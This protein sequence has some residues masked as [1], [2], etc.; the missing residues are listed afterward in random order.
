M[1]IN[2][3]ILVFCQFFLT[4]DKIDIKEGEAI[5]PPRE[6][7]GRV[8][9]VKKEKVIRTE[10]RNN[11][12][13]AIEDEKTILEV[14][15]T[16]PHAMHFF[17][18]ANACTVVQSKEDLQKQETELAKRNEEIKKTNKLIHD[19][20]QKEAIVKRKKELDKKKSP[21]ANSDVE[22][23]KDLKGNEIKVDL[24]DMNDFGYQEPT[25]MPVVESPKPAPVYNYT[26]MEPSPTPEV[27]P[28]PTMGPEV[29]PIHALPT[30]NKTKTN[31]KS[32]ES[33][34]PVEKNIDT[35]VKSIFKDI[36]NG[37]KK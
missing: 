7:I 13:F 27:T 29:E 4:T 28:S 17:I 26:V 33:K 19:K 34:K 12:I 2:V 20:N 6:M 18:N 25:P 32:E 11:L 21:V 36:L 22:F 15:G 24:S 14:E 9:N 3:G 16:E 37:F 1:T 5:A 30:E 8:I 23:M 31:F 35:G 10:K